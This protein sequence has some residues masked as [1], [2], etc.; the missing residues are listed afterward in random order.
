M[1]A[2]VMIRVGCFC[3]GH[4]A[5]HFCDT[6][7][8]DEY[9]DLFIEGLREQGCVPHVSDYLLDSR[10]RKR[11]DNACGLSVINNK[12]RRRRNK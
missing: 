5:V 11:E 1:K 8:A 4:A 7:S 12:S 3:P 2:Q 9:I 10:G 6:S